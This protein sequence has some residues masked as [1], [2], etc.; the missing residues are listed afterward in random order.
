MSE[1]NAKDILAAGESKGREGL[2]EEMSDNDEGIAIEVS[3]AVENN[4]AKGK[5]S[6][7]KPDKFATSKDVA[8]DMKKKRKREME[9]SKITPETAGK[10]AKVKDFGGEQKQRMPLEVQKKN[11]PA[12]KKNILNSLMPVCNT[13]EAPTEGK[14]K[15]DFPAK[16]K[17]AEK[18]SGKGKLK[19]KP[20]DKGNA[21]S[22]ATSKKVVSASSAWQLMKQN[23][24]VATPT[25]ISKAEGGKS[26]V[27]ENV[28]KP[29]GFKSPSQ[30]DVAKFVQVKKPKGAGGGIFDSLMPKSDW[31]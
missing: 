4:T 11:Q 18:L 19:E 17:S 13:D 29:K 14:S 3:A 30:A 5:E 8:S 28:E 22:S 2:V 1:A 10:K 27:A 7:Q 20:Q 15:G 9:Q 12:E 6:K 16:G 24:S 23:S 31:E 26:K 21:G 25:K